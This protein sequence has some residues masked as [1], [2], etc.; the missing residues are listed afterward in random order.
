M[1]KRILV[2]GLFTMA[3]LPVLAQDYPRFELG[4]GYSYVRANVT[5][6]DQMVTPAVSASEGF[7][8]Q[9]G[10]GNIVYNPTRSIGLVADFA[11][12]DV[13][14]LPKGTGASATLFTYMFGPRFTYRGNEKFQPFAHVLLG[15][16][17]VSGSGSTLVATA[18]SGIPINE[19]SGSSNSFAMAI[20]GG[21]D[22]KVAN[23][24]A[25]RLFEGDYLLTRFNT[26][27]N[28]AG[29]LTAANQNN[30]RLA[31]GIQFRF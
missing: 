11:G 27:L 21:F 20:G 5:A 29:K 7:N 23:H 2:L 6:K 3:A 10:G 1:F 16:A 28:S 12:Y 13:T 17:H 9:G 8:L 24:V 4:A 30:F 19:F 22:V 18:T 31:A 15:G 26:T 25:L 14:G